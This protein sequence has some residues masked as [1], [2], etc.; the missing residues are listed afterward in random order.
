[1][2]LTKLK[3]TVLMIWLSVFLMLPMTAFGAD[4]DIYAE[5]TMSETELIVYLYA[6]VNVQNLVSYGVSLNYDPAEL[7]VAEVLKDTDP[8]PYT[9]NVTKWYLGDSSASYKNNPTP[10]TSVPGEIIIIGGKLDPLNPTQGVGQ[11]SKVFLA[12]VRFTPADV[13]IPASPTL[14]LSYAKGDGTSSFKNFVRLDNNT[15]LVLDGGNVYFGS[16]QVSEPGDADANGAI[17]P[18]DINMIK[19]NIGNADGPCYMDC[20]GNGSITPSD[21]NCTKSKI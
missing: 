5:G 2:N 7:V 13:Q 6:D 17:T 21:I 12:M 9:S 10:D 11:G 18:S 19:M 3:K 20:D 14:F 8:I 16:V 4:V 15:P 1:M